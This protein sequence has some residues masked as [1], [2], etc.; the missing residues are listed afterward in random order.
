MSYTM[1]VT[2]K[3][4]D[5]EKLGRIFNIMLWYVG[6]STEIYVVQHDILSPDSTLESI[7]W[8]LIQPPLI[9]DNDNLY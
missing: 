3:D 5:I 4:Y 8:N 9:I 1:K 2:M 6:S 7:I